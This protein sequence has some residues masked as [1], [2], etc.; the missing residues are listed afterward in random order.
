[1]ARSADSVGQ[2][3]T[4]GVVEGVVLVI[5]L[6]ALLSIFFQLIGV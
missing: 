4:R 1:V 3:T 2:A 6:D 5:V